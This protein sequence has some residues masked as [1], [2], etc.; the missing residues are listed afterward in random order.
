MI[1]GTLK[2]ILEVK[3]GETKSPLSP[4]ELM[5]STVFSVPTARCLCRHSVTPPLPVPSLVPE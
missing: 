4:C 1:G 3:G 2:A 5:S